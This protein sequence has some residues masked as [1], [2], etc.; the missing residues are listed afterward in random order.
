MSK[1]PAFQWYPNDYIRDTRIL[2]LSARGAWADMLNFMWYAPDRGMLTGTYE[3]LARQLSCSIEEIKNVLNELSVTKT[4]D[5]TICNNLVTVIN[6]RMYR[7][8]RERKLTRSRVQKHR[9]AKCNATS[10]A[11]KTPPSST[12]TSSSTSNIN[13]IIDFIL[14]DFIP[15]DTWDAYI[16]VRKKKR[17]AD[18]TYALNLVIRELEK[19]KQTHNHDPVDVLNQSIVSGWTDV[20]PLKGGNNGNGNGQRSFRSKQEVVRKANGAQSDGSPWPEDRAY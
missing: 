5:V 10:N 3:Q 18:T 7:D 16:Q 12:S 14:P 2:S 15:K 4:A 1:A 19:I 13:N 9:N 17:A 20:Y 11:D 8:E 6:R